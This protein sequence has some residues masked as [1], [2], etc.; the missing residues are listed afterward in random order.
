MDESEADNPLATIGWGEQYDPT[1]ISG[2][3][4]ANL[5]YESFTYAEDEH[6]YVLAYED[7]A[8]RRLSE[9]SG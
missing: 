9:T 7:I 5:I 2:L 3:R 8:T 4:M 6:W 1:M